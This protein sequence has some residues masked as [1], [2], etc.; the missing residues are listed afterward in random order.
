MDFKFWSL[1]FPITSDNLIYQS[2]FLDILIGIDARHISECYCCQPS[3]TSQIEV[4]L[5]C[6][7][8]YSFQR[9]YENIEACECL[10]CQSLQRDDQYVKDQPLA[11]LTEFIPMNDEGSKSL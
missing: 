7:R 8:G 5:K 1:R 9:V 6:N 4:V 10:P 2:F 11:D 3:K